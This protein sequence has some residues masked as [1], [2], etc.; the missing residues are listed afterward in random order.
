[1]T[2][3]LSPEFLERVAAAAA[4]ADLV[5]AVYDRVPTPLGTL[6]VAQTERGLCRLG[7]AGE[8][9]DRVLAQVAAGVG[10]RV[11]ASR[12][13]TAPAREALAAYLE[14]E[15]D[16]L[17]DLPVDLTLARSPFQRAVLETLRERVHAGEVTTYSE[18]ANTIGRPGAMRA[19]G[20]ALGRNPVPIVVPCHRVLPRGGGVGGYGGGPDVKRRLLELEGVT[21]P[22]GRIASRRSQ[23]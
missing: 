16:A 11:V 5:D 1:M 2:P 17:D 12:D 7:F 9:E 18:L 6:L 14:G 23:A 13:A 8:P 15:A 3:T 20:T 22:S 4:D 10:P 21:V 19:T